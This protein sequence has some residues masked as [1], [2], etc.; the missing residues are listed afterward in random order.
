[1]QYQ[2]EI[3]SFIPQQF[4]E[5]YKEHGP[6]FI[7]FMQ[8][9]YEWMEQNNPQYTGSV[10][11]QARSLPEYWD[12]DET[13]D[14][15]IVYFKQNYLHAIPSNIAANERLLVKHIKELYLSKGSEKSYKL[16]FRLLFNEDVELY[17]PSDNIFTLSDSKWTVPKYIEVTES[18]FL[19]QLT[20]LRIMSSSGAS[21]VVES[22]SVSN[23]DADKFAYILYLSNIEGVFRYG[24]Q[25]LCS[26]IPALTVNNAPLIVGSLSSINITNGGFN[27]NVGDELTISS[28]YGFGGKATV[29]A[30]TSENGKVNFTLQSGGYGYTVNAVV[31]VIGGYGTGATFQV[32]GLTDIQFITVNTDKINNFLNTTL[33][34]GTDA[35]TNWGPFP[36]A[37][38]NT[39]LQSVIGQTLNWETL[40]IGRI[41]YLKNINP[42]SGYSANP[43]VTV[44]EPLV[45]ALNIQDGAGNYWGND[46]I[47]TATALNANGIVTAINIKD[48]GFGYIPNDNLY[49]S[50][51]NNNV[52][53]T[54]SSI[55][56]Q[57]G[58]S[59]GYWENNKSFLSDTQ[60]LQDSF[61]YQTYSYE[62]ISSK[63]IDSYKKIVEDL[64]HPAGFNMLGRFKLKSEFAFST[65]V[66]A[67][68]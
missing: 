18:P 54:G 39:N 7:A 53:V 3:S 43:T 21:A 12:I 37:I 8:A 26:A 55:V 17:Y 35:N 65:T 23:I 56:S 44:V 27:Y 9:Y 38:G 66:L 22:Y 42:G 13:L 19:A 48:S 1:M 45:A 5:F 59:L 50:N 31:S 36:A 33:Q 24:D 68:F 67:N 49:M 57:T 28:T 47:V 63:M 40:Q 60:K 58:K 16:L 32:G 52:S 20:G 2:K 30:I 62:I 10:T 14:Q 46:A 15:F 25:I 64:I 61:Y 29:A 34:L 6:N 4:P 41:T 11:Y 51:A